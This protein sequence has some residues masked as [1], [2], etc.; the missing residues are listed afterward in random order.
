MI[1]GTNITEPLTEELS[2]ASW[3]SSGWSFFKSGLQYVKGLKHVLYLKDLLVSF[4]KED[5]GFDSDTLLKLI[6]EES[7]NGNKVRLALNEFA[8]RLQS[9]KS[10]FPGLDGSDLKLLEKLTGQNKIHI[11]KLKDKELQRLVKL[12]NKLNNKTLQNQRSLIYIAFTSSLLSG[13]YNLKWAKESL[14]PAEASLLLSQDAFKQAA[15]QYTLG[16]TESA[17]TNFYGACLKFG[18]NFAVTYAMDAMDVVNPYARGAVY[19]GLYYF[20]GVSNEKLKQWVSSWFYKETAKDT[21]SLEASPEEKE[22]ISSFQR[23]L[24]LHKL[25]VISEEQRKS[26]LTCFNSLKEERQKT[27]HTKPVSDCRMKF[28]ENMPELYKSYKDARPR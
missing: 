4:N 18:A 24:N 19:A 13:H 22:L 25:K 17:K 8:S 16:N 11:T 23:L 27:G 28:K 9:Q 21:K 7:T 6:K 3:L 5:V 20:N 1:N 12:Y 14:L 26:V 2:E 15:M 10:G